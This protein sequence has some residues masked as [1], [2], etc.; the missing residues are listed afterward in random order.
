MVAKK[1]V[2]AD[3]PRQIPNQGKGGALH[4]LFHRFR[5]APFGV[6]GRTVRGNE[7]VPMDD[8]VIRLASG[9]PVSDRR[10]S[11]AADKN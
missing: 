3:P 8:E 10:T 11:S 6:P 4:S 5:R 1:F 7:E 2:T 9:A